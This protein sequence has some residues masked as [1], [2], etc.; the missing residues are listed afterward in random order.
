[1]SINRAVK[2]QPIRALCRCGKMRMEAMNCHILSHRPRTLYI[3]AFLSGR[4]MVKCF[5]SAGLG[6][7]RETYLLWFGRRFREVPFAPRL[8]TLFEFLS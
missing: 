8:A 4:S 2:L 7:E 3:L 5:I 1:M 6:Q